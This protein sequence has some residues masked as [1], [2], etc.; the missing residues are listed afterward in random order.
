MY[1]KKNYKQFCQ[2]IKEY[3]N[4]NGYSPTL[5]EISI[6]FG[7][8]RARTHQVLST[9]IKDKIVYNNDNAIR[10]TELCKKF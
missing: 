10:K 3:K 4:K 1:I 6:K 7:I 9:M 2:F 5:N 8:S